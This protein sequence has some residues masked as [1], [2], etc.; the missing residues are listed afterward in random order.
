M[1]KLAQYTKELDRLAAL[2]LDEEADQEFERVAHELLGIDFGDLFDADVERIETLVPSPGIAAG[3]CKSLGYDITGNATPT[4]MHWWA[5]SVLIVAK[6]EG[7]VP[8][9]PAARAERRA[10]VE[11]DDLAN[12]ENEETVPDDL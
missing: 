8:T 2:E 9:D 5:F 4:V 3:V 6:S 11:A 7:I 12:E 1:I 10:A